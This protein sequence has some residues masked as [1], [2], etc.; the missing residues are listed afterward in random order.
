LKREPESYSFLEALCLMGK[1]GRS[2][3]DGCVGSLLFQNAVKLPHD[4][5]A[6]RTISAMPLCLDDRDEAPK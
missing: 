4:S 1:E 3:D 5:D 6:Y 2:S